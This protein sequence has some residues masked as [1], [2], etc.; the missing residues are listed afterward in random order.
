M[1]APYKYVCDLCG[2]DDTAHTDGFIDWDVPSQSW[3]FLGPTDAPLRCACGNRG[4]DRF[5]KTPVTDLK[6][7]AQITIQQE[8]TT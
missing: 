1:N 7:L 2:A 6:T 5:T 3:V 8:Q 4:D